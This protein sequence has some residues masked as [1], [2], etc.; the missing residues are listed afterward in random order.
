MKAIN[1][2]SCTGYIEGYYGQLL[3]WDDRSKLVQQLSERGL[4]SYFYAPKE[5]IYHRLQWREPYPTDWR[6]AFSAWASSAH[7]QSVQIIAGVAPGLDFDFSHLSDGPDFLALVNKSTQLLNDGASAIALLMDD[8]NAEFDP[9][10]SG[11]A[12]EGQAHAM[13]ANA[14]SE[15]INSAIYV[16]PRVYARELEYESTDYA[17]QFSAQLTTGNV[18]FHCGTHIVAPTVEQPDYE[19][20]SDSDR[21]RIVV[22]DNLYANDYCPRRLFV[23]AWLGRSA[24]S[25]IML[26]PTGMPATDALLIDIMANTTNDSN[27]QTVQENALRHHGVPEQFLTVADYFYHPVF[28]EPTS[29]RSVSLEPVSTESVLQAAAPGASRKQQLAAIEFLLWK[30]KTPLSREWYP[31]LFGLKHDLLISS[32]ELADIRIEKTQLAPLTMRLRSQ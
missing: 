23:G 9:S 18:V 15:R 13:L 24:V 26:N 30:W 2:A 11:L 16:V 27:A 28:S 25:E 10:Q 4:S 17:R 7:A 5:D 32:N 14:L 8:I 22:W 20:Y 3:S 29:L 31:Y 6:N 19:D 1:T 21:H 12:T